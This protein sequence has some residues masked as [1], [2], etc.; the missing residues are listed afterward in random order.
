MALPLAAVAAIATG[1]PAL[2]LGTHAEVRDAA[3]ALTGAQLNNVSAQA[4]AVAAAGTPVLVQVQVESANSTTAI[5]EAEALMNGADIESVTGAQDGL[6]MLVD[7]QPG[8]NNQHGSAALYAGHRLSAGR[9]PQTELSRL[10]DNIMSPR[11]LSGDLSGALTATLA[12]V[13][14]DLLSGPPAPTLARGVA[15]AVAAVPLNIAALVLLIVV[16]GRARRVWLRRNRVAAPVTET[17]EPPTDDEPAIA[18]AVWNGHPT[19]SLVLATVFD[20]ARRGALTIESTDHKHYVVRLVDESKAHAPWERVVWL[21]LAD[22]SRQDGT[23]PTSRLG[24]LRRNFAAFRTQL[25]TDLRDRGLY[26]ADADRE[27]APLRW[28][29]WISMALVVVDA[30][31]ALIG[32]QAWAL[33]GIAVACT[34][35]VVAFGVAATI[36][37]NTDTGAALAARWEGFRRGLVAAAGKPDEQVARAIDVEHCLPW[38]I[39]LAC[40]R[41]IDPLLVR[42]DARGIQPR[43]LVPTQGDSGFYGAWLGVDGGFG[44]G[45]SSASM[46]GGAAG[47]GAGA[48][49]SF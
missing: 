13:H 21:R 40:T 43:W 22:A 49:G 47:G 28:L 4:T 45:G 20:L 6:V 24:G 38:A 25:I 12:A 29:A 26:S 33:P 18:G 41:D 7:I 15:A 16:V 19:R 48:G 44:G 8:T 1:I 23:I 5:A 30:A 27:A 36:S 32:H 31:A 46:G 42:A 37:R 11:L 34:S 17:T 39:A 2:A 3:H 9:L 10:Y 35:A 14:E